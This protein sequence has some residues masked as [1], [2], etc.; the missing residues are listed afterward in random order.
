M[1]LRVGWGTEHLTVPMLSYGLYERPT[2]WKSVSVSEWLTHWLTGVGARD[3]IITSKKACFCKSKANKCAEQNLNEK[4]VQLYFWQIDLFN[5]LS[6]CRRVE[7]TV[8][9]SEFDEA[10]AGCSK[11]SKGFP[12]QPIHMVQVQTHLVVTSQSQVKWNV[13]L[14]LWLFLF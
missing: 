6:G 9:E 4:I 2:K 10:G 13:S 12:V 14:E 5:L 11:H 7:V 8:A 3:A 1:D